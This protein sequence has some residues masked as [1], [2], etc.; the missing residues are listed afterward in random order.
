MCVVD[1]VLSDH[2]LLPIL[3]LYASLAV[4][5]AIAANVATRDAADGPCNSKRC[6]SRSSIFWRCSFTFEVLSRSLPDSRRS[7]HLD[8]QFEV[9]RGLKAVL[10][11]LFREH[12]Q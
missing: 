3:I 10:H 8:T 2:G 1:I 7:S 11:E 9:P 4:G 6:T 5:R 12:R